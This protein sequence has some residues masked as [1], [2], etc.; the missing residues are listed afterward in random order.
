M[1]DKKAIYLTENQKLRVKWAKN[2]LHWTVEQW[3]KVI[4]SD[5]SPFVYR[6]NCRQKIWLIKGDILRANKFTGTVKHD[7]KINVWG[8][9]SSHGVGKLH[10][11]PGVMD[12]NV[13]HGILRRQLIPSGN[14]LFP[15]STT[16]D[17]TFQEDND[18]K[19]TSQLCKNYLK[20]K[21]IDR[22]PWPAQSPDLN[23]IENLWAILNR[24]AAT[25][26]PQTDA[27][28]FTALETSWNMLDQSILEKLVDSMPRRCKMV[29][30]SRGLPIDY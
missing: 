24:D 2:H 4:W 29:I 27:E 20:E 3:R 28:L 19:H 8:C 23:P 16:E 7:K 14:I 22:M 21:K 12:K 11:I 30:A 15:G 9:F 1:A 25:R 18:P 5:E 13:Y 17:W 10:H 6:Y 26:K